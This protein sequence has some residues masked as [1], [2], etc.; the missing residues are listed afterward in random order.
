MLARGVQTEA[1]TIPP[2]VLLNNYAL[3]DKYHVKLW[4]TC[5][6][7]LNMFYCDSLL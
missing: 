3:K 4:V 5:S 7:L 6:E 1:M 2:S